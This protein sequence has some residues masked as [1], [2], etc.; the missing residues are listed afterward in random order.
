M[1]DTVNGP[2]TARRARLPIDD[3]LMAGK[4]GTAQAVGLS[5]GDGK[6]TEWRFRHHGLFVFFAPFENPRYAGAVVVE[7]GGGSGAAT[8]IAR[9]VMTYLF[10]PG[11]GMEALHGLEKEWGGTARERLD[12]RYAEY[13]AAAGEVVPPIP[14]RE[15][16]VFDAVEAEA[17]LPAEAREEAMT[18]LSADASAAAEPRGG[19]GPQAAT[20]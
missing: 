15:R 8:P 2:G 4:T 3:V 16:G 1:G 10:D 12:R 5:R 20:Q 11:K 19:S 7:H 18:E 17:R 14:V 9:D 6:N 13:A